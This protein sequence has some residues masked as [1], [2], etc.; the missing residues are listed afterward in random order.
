MGNPRLSARELRTIMYN[1]IIGRFL[2]DYCPTNFGSTH[3]TVVG[4]VFLF[5]MIVSVGWTAETS[6][7]PV[8]TY[9]FDQQEMRAQLIPQRYTTLSA[10][11]GA[12][13]NRINIK[14]GERFQ[15]G[16]VLVQFD[17]TSQAAQLDKARSQLYAATNTWS[18]H[19][20]MAQLNAVGQVELRNSAAEVEKAK[21]DV[22]YL[23][24]MIDKCTIAAPFGGRVVEQ[25][26]RENQ[27]V[28]AG[29]PLL[30]ILDDSALE[31]EIMAPSR[32]LVWL[33]PGYP[34]EV[35]IDDT[36]KTYPVKLLRLGAKVDPVSQTIKA[37]AVIDGHFPELIAGMSGNILLLPKNTE[38]SQASQKQ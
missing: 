35:R 26:A 8:A 25:K 4:V 3:H 23:R 28:Q 15:A 20:R 11:V 31:L 7:P 24:V 12:K 10:E 13:I 9:S 6:A 22:A 1:T 18:G 33:K 19:K 30:D 36:G 37:V 16:H 14:E 21:A 32:W 38:G 27:F 29:Q 5:F 2:N 34:F 17:C